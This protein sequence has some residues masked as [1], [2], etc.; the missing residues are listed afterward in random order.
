MTTGRLVHK[1]T[2]NLPTSAWDI[3]IRGFQSKKRYRLIALELARMGFHVA[4]RTIARRA[5]DWRAEQLRRQAM[6]VAS[7]E[8][9]RADLL[10][11]TISILKVLD[12]KP[13]WAMRARR[14]VQRAVLGFFDNPDG[15]HAQSVK[16]ELLRFRLEQLVSQ[17]RAVGAPEGGGRAQALGP[18]NS[19][20]GNAGGGHDGIS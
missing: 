1:S 11:E 3:M 12:L 20:A 13:G 8:G 2:D 16:R 15:E 6:K 7:T 17:A 18:E 14:R 19:T 4:E 9:A 10:E 5:V